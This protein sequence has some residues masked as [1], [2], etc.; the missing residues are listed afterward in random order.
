MRILLVRHAETIENAEGRLQGHS[1]GKLSSL[2]V[3]QAKALGEAL[4]PEAISH[5]YGSPLDRAARTLEAV[6]AHHPHVEAAFST[7]LMERSQGVWEGCTHSELL[8]L[9][10]DYQK[11]MLLRDFRPGGGETLAELNVRVR[12]F[13]DLLAPLLPTDETVFIAGHGIL[14]KEMLRE[15]LK[16]QVTFSQRNACINEIILEPGYV[17]VVRINDTAHLGG[18]GK[19]A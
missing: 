1:H 3:M 9:E 4:K 17:K 19:F 11:K 5:F 10:P 6:R 15:I 13:L 8:E 16:T 2:G 12:R 14:N 18:L 7:D